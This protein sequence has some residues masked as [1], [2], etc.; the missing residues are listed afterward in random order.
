MV[1][2][3]VLDIA[4]ILD[5]T[6]SMSEEID[7]VKRTVQRVA[8]VVASRKLA[9]RFSLVEYKDR[10]DEFLVRVHP[11]TRDVAGFVTRIQKVTADGGGDRPEDVIEGLR[12]GLTKVEWSKGSAVRLA[13]LVGDAPPQLGYGNGSYV[14]AMRAANRAGIV[15]HTIAASGMDDLGQMVWRQVAQYTGGTNLFVLRGGAGPQSTGAGDAKSSCGTTHDNFTSGNLDALITAKVE[16]AVSALEADPMRIA[17]LGQDELSKPCAQRIASHRS[18]R[19]SLDPLV[20]EPGSRL[21]PSWPED[22]SSSP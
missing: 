20:R 3:L 9:V 5:T 6:G 21:A 11:M 1:I 14:D 2:D 17:G 18:D 8:L 22:Y 19:L 13:F 4:F 7:A 10:G 16:R 12:A 15:L